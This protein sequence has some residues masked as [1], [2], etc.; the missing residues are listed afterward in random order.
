M[1]GL[2]DIGVGLGIQLTENISIWE[3][4]WQGY[5]VYRQA[6]DIGIDV[7]QRITE[8]LLII[9]GVPDTLFT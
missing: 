4:K 6:S 2:S 1:T 8:F 7:Y 5:N 3:T 9:S